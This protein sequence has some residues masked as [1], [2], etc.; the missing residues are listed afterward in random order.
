MNPRNTMIAIDKSY[1]NFMTYRPDRIEGNIQP[2]G[3]DIFQEA[4]RGEHSMKLR[5]PRNHAVIYAG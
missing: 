5:F 4:I 3:Q 2:I 1:I